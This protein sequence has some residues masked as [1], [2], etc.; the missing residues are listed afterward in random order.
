MTNEPNAPDIDLMSRFINA[1]PERLQPFRTPMLRDLLDVGAS[2]GHS[3][4]DLAAAVIGQCAR[5]P[6]ARP[7]YAIACL[8]TLTDLR[9]GL[10][11]IRVE[12]ILCGNGC[13]GG[14][15]GEDA[16]GRPRPC[17]V[18][19]P[20]LRRCPGCGVWVTT[21]HA[22]MGKPHQPTGYPKPSEDNRP[23]NPDLR[24]WERQVRAV[25]E[26]RALAATE[27][28]PPPEEPTW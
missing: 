24:H 6:G 5:N 17:P 22:C 1:L 19:K 21:G 28:A 2:N 18:C 15:L 20:H 25:L 26:R 14:W 9:G 3:P 8:G 10:P 12:R 11:G 4:E 13:V 7:G 27:A 23:H 16:E